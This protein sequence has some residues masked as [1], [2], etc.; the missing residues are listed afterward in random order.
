MAILVGVIAPQLIRYI[1]KANISADITT[2]DSIRSAVTYACSDPK[3]ATST[4]A[5]DALPLKG[6]YGDLGSTTA[7]DIAHNTV[8][9]GAKFKSKDL[10]KTGETIDNVAVEVNE[11]GQVHVSIGAF[12]I[13]FKGKVSSPDGEGGTTTTSGDGD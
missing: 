13:D 2:L 1:E 7:N 6:T 4:I 10:K 11:Q 3:F 8:P 9:L 5:G 12:D